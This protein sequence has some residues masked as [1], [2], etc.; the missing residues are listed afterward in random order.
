VREREERET[1]AG[2]STCPRPPP[3]Q[4]APCP[5][6]RWSTSSLRPHHRASVVSVGVAWECE[7]GAKTIW[8]SSEALGRPGCALRAVRIRYWQWSVRQL[9]RDPPQC[10]SPVP[11][12]WS[13]NSKLACV[14]HEYWARSSSF[15]ALSTLYGPSSSCVRHIDASGLR[16]THRTAK[17][18][19]RI[20]SE[21]LARRD[22]KG[23]LNDGQIPDFAAYVYM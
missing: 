8:V 14:D 4:S 12:G 15:V 22:R 23:S 18:R 2:T 5:W 16:T 7:P 19:L 6:A 21:G 10:A 9:L 20:V 13:T 17:K 11:T 3:S 1:P